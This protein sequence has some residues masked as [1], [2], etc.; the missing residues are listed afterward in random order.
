MDKLLELL[1][2]QEIKVTD[3]L[4]QELQK[5]WDG[6]IQE[7]QEEGKKEI[8]TDNLFTQEEL[9]EKI[10][11]R[12]ARE[13]DSYEGEL[14]ELRGK[15]EQL[16]DPSKLEEVKS[17]FE[18]KAKEAEEQ[19]NEA[20]KEYELRLQA[21]KEGALDEDYIVFQA[22]KRG[23]FDRLSLDDGGKV[24]LVDGEGD[25]AK[26]KDGNVQGIDA[27][28]DSLKEELPNQFKE[29]QE[30]KPKRDFSTTNPPPGSTDLAKDEKKKRSR[31]MAAELGYS[32]KK[33]SE[34]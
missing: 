3:A 33:E 14:K 8:N 12:L 9:N 15:M 2:K 28:I 18:T 30:P 13:R 5:V 6:A 19:R 32:K 4:K 31:E 34:E 21:A 26:D 22:R 25:P 23:E 24:I 7:A 1:Q 17:E 27:F 29:Q 11:K 20:V 10:Q 16:V